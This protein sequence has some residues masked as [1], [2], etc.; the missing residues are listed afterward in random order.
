MSDLID[1]AEALKCLEFT[2]DYNTLNEVH[3]RLSKLPSVS[4]PKTGRWIKKPYLQPLPMDCLPPCN[5]DDYDEETHSE[6]T[7]KIVCDQCSY[8]KDILIS[9]NFC[10][11]CG[12]DMR[13]DDNENSTSGMI[14]DKLT[15]DDGEPD[16]TGGQIFCP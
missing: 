4:Q 8:E 10:P 1:R 6:R 7:F 3:E 16:G 15:T 12:A 5:I 14:S 11:N 13:G 9:Y 2:G